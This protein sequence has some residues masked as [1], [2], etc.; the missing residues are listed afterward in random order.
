[1]S[2]AMAPVKK[3]LDIETLRAWRVRLHDI[4]EPTTRYLQD[5]DAMKN[6]VIKQNATIAKALIKEIEEEMGAFL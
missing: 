4:V 1:M 2:A 3:E 6:A 5:Q